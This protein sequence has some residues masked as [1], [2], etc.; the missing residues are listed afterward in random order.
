MPKQ[1]YVGHVVPIKNKI[2]LCYYAIFVKFAVLM[3]LTIISFQ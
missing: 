2:Y 1:N 3:Q